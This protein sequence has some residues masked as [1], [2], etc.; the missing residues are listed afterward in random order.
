[1][2]NDISTTNLFSVLRLDLHDNGKKYL[3]WTGILIGALA[4]ITC[5]AAIQTYDS[6]DPS[7]WGRYSSGTDPMNDFENLLFWFGII[8]LGCISASHIFTPLGSKGGAISNLMLPST[9]LNKYLSRWIILVPA[10][11]LVYYVC[12]LI[13]DLG[14]YLVLYSLLDNHTNLHLFGFDVFYDMGPTIGK[15]LLLSLA[16]LTQSFFVIGSAI[17]PKHGF[18]YT[19]LW[20]FAIQAICSI[21]AGFYYSFLI[22]ADSF[23]DFNGF[24]EEAFGWTIVGFAFFGTLLNYVLAYFRYREMEIVPRW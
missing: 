22:D 5:F 16:L 3:M 19:A 10:F 7:R 2:K 12:F 9:Q 8:T 24:N 20:L 21:A 23:S 15:F 11:I 6:Y 1:M 17:W 18:L 14:R 4:A 13:V